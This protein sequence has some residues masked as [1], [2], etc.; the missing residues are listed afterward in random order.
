M[1]EKKSIYESNFEIPNRSFKVDIKYPNHKYKVS[2]FYNNKYFE[3][4]MYDIL[5]NGYSGEFGLPVDRITDTRNDYYF[6]DLKNAKAAIEM[7]DKKRST[8]LILQN[9]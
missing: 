3:R 7:F 1:A 6:S 9:L 2:V 8:R 4:N 5:R